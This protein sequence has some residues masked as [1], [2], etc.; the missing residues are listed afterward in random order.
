MQSTRHLVLVW[1]LKGSSTQDYYK[2][3]R[4]AATTR[5]GKRG[6]VKKII[7]QDARS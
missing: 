6:K 3:R 2:K 7:V 4:E 5:K 1:I